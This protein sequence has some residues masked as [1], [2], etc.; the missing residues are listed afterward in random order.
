MCIIDALIAS[1]RKRFGSAYALAF[2]LRIRLRASLCRWGLHTR[3]YGR[4]IAEGRYVRRFALLAMPIAR[5]L[6]LCARVRFAHTAPRVAMSLGAPYAPPWS[7]YR[8]RAIRATFCAIG[9]AN[10]ARASPMRSRAYRAYGYARR[11]VAGGSIRAAMVALSPRGDTGD[12]SRYW[13]CQYARGLRLCARVRFAHTAPRV[14]MSPWAPYAPPWSPYRRRRYVRRFALLA[15]PIRARAPPMRSRAYRAYGSAR[16]YVAGG[17]IRA[18]M[19]GFCFA[20]RRP[21]GEIQAPKKSSEP[22]T[23]ADRRARSKARRRFGRHE[24]KKN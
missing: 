11:Y 6:R 9:D 21:F 18:A 24:T 19:V 23:D 10:S 14:A 13:L 2:A 1:L 22:Q 4:P 17:S 15:M 5:G 20:I 12:V 16:R 8:R 7:P 3:R